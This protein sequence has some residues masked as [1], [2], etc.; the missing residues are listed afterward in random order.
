MS[1]PFPIFTGAGCSPIDETIVPNG[2]ISDSNVFLENN[3]TPFFDCIKDIDDAT[4]N[5]IADINEHGGEICASQDTWSVEVAMENPVGTPPGSDCQELIL[6]RYVADQEVEEGQTSCIDWRVQLKCGTTAIQNFSFG[7][8]GDDPPI[9][10]HTIS[11][12]AYDNITDHDD[13]RIN[14]R[15]QVGLEDAMSKL[16]ALGVFIGFELEYRTK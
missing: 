7:A 4:Q 1:F 3:C 13:L 5:M 2:E 8:Q 6:R 12:A 10:E 15:Y 14:I 9:V 11:D 16:P